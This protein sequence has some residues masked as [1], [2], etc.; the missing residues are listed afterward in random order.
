MR[1]PLTLGDFLERAELVHG[2]RPGVVDEPDAP[3]GAL[4]TVT[5]RRMGELARAQAAGLDAL[6]VGPGER[7]AVVSPNAARLLVSF[8]GVSGFGPEPWDPYEYT[9]ATNN[10]KS[11]TTT[12]PKGAQM[13][14][15]SL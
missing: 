13:T 14:H 5:Y 12:R 6:G 15:R 8:F 11:G 1:V 9:N 7:V 10:Y 3:G 4:G 2:D